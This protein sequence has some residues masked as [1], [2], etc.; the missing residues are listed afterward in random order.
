MPLLALLLV[1]G[2]VEDFERDSIFS[3]WGSDER[4]RRKP[5]TAFEMVAGK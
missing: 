2:N 3:G 4:R 1:V 5:V